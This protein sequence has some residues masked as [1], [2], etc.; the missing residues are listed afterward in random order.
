MTGRFDLFHALDAEKQQRILHA[1]MEEFATQGYERASTN[2]IVKAAGIGKGMLFYYFGSKE[3][4]YEFLCEYALQPP[5]AFLQQLHFADGDFLARYLQIAKH[6]QDMMASDPL[7]M[8]FYESLYRKNAHTEKFATRLAELQQQMYHKLYD[9]LDYSL[10]R[11]DIPPVTA[12]QYMRWLL[13]RM[14]QD[15][16]ASI[17]DGSTRTGP[18]QWENYYAFLA[19]LRKLFYK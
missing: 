16:T 13:E 4:L 1:A 5:A 10:L 2:A 12:I 8:R 17:K 9:G 3:E 7:L 19:D 6:K 14:E 18:E 11:D 15:V